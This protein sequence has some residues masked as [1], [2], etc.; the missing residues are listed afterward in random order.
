MKVRPRITETKHNIYSHYK[1]AVLV[2][3]ILFA[4]IISQILLSVATSSG[5]YEIASAKNNLKQLTES[6]DKTNQIVTALA[7]PQSLASKAEKLGMVSNST[8]AFL[9]LSDGAVLGS[10]MPADPNAKLILDGGEIPN[11]QLDKAIGEEYNVQKNILQPESTTNDSIYGSRP[12]IL[13][14]LPAVSTH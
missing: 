4:I 2:L 14:R 1:N 9:R 6:Y 3:I 12:Q 11:A 8:P 10:P 7:S 5:A 13:I